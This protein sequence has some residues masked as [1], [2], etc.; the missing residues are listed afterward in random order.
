MLDSIEILRSVINYDRLIVNKDDCLQTLN[1]FQTYSYPE[2]GDSSD[3]DIPL[4]VN[5]D[6]MDETRYAIT[7]YESR[8]LHK[9]KDYAKAA[10]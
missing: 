7:F 2:D 4:K 6:A 1:E 10:G 5:D 9:I 8:F 3:P